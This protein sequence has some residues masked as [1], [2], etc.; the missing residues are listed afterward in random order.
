MAQGSLAKEPSTKAIRSNEAET[1]ATAEPQLQAGAQANGTQL[2]DRR[3]QKYYEKALANLEAK[4]FAKAEL[5]FKAATTLLAKSKHDP[6]F[7]R[8]V[9]TE[10]AMMLTAQ[11]RKAEAFSISKMLTEK[12]LKESTKQIQIMDGGPMLINNGS[13]P[14]L[15]GPLPPDKQ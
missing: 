2:A 8:Q 10:Y 15:P 6:A 9:W 4:Q 1:Q 14:P 11:N 13:T 5:N 3:A 12:R 7:E